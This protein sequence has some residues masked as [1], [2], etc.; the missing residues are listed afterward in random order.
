MRTSG[1]S[2]GR[3]AKRVQVMRSPTAN[4]DVWTRA[5]WRTA[6]GRG[7]TNILE[8]VPLTMQQPGKKKEKR[9]K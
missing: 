7:S 8:P 3:A 1:C 4:G 6:L 2:Q 9:T 5:V